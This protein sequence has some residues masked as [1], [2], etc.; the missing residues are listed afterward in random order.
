MF[1]YSKMSENSRIELENLV[2]E[3]PYCQTIQILYL[4]NLKCLSVNAFNTRL[5]H[6]AIHV[7]NRKRL[8]SEVEKVGKILAKEIGTR[9]FRQA[10]RLEFAVAERSRSHT[11]HPF[12][13]RTISE[14]L[15]L[16]TPTRH[17]EKNNDDKFLEQQRLEALAKVNARLNEVRE[18]VT[19]KA[20]F[21][22][23]PTRKKTTKE[24]IDKVI[25]TNPKISKIDDSF[26][27]KLNKST[28]W[29]DKEEHSL[30]EN[31]ELVSE[32]LA[33]LYIAQGAYAKASEI[34]KTLSK[35]HP[36]KADHFIQISKQIKQN[37]KS[38]QK[39]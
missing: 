17:V 6:T 33:R 24:I 37:H 22:D 4:L 9:S 39:K 38:K 10:Q 5:P 19:T 18:T 1:D 34:Y 32:T 21:L 23:D 8:K 2:E 3:Y 25:A 13:G 11:S 12:K 7:S 35:I 26:N 31:F 15:N 20:N 30:R 28:H 14:R 29:K 36:E 16:T 27:T